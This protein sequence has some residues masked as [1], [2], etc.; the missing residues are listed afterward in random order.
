MY[1]C[2]YVCMYAYMQACMYLCM[3]TYVHIIYIYSDIWSGTYMTYIL[4]HF[5]AIFS[6]IS[7][8]HSLH[9]QCSHASELQ[10]KFQQN[11]SGLWRNSHHNAVCPLPSWVFQEYTRSYHPFGFCLKILKIGCVC[12]YIYIPPGPLVSLFINNVYH[13]FAGW[14]GHPEVSRNGDSSKSSQIRPFLYWNIGFGESPIT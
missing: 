3:Y 14:N 6:G 11:F 4:L 1:V 10:T 5:Y 8:L 9:I 12:I 2:M 13:H 7:G